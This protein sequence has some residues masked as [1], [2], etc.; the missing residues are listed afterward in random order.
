MHFLLGLIGSFLG[1][2]V[3]GPINLSV[4]ELTIR[5]NLQSALKFISAASLVEILQAFIAVFFGKLISKKIDEFPEFRLLIIAFFL[6]LGLVFILKNN[7]SKIRLSEETDSGRGDFFSGIIVAILN[8]QAIPYWIF[9]L[10]YL[11]TLEMIDLSMGNL[12][13]FLAGVST[14]KF[15]ILTV[16]G[17]LS[18]YIKN[19]LSNVDH[20]IST[21]IGGLLILIGLIQ[22]IDYYFFS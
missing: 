20:L 5:K 19:R 22:A 13:L 9:V 15:L 2:V 18:K 6:V 12:L 14:G 8:P 16:Y 3:F 11:Q 7:N 4:V 1:G 10:T 21:F 17:Y